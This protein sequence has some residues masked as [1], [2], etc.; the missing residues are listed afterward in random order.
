MGKL[1]QYIEQ[2]LLDMY[3][4]YTYNIIPLTYNLYP[5]LLDVMPF[6]HCE[7]DDGPTD[8]SDIRLN[9]SLP[10]DNGVKIVHLWHLFNPFQTMSYKGAQVLQV[11]AKLVHKQMWRWHH[12]KI[13]VGSFCR[14][15]V[16]SQDGDDSISAVRRGTRCSGLCISKD[17]S[18][19][20]L[21]DFRTCASFV[22]AWLR[23]SPRGIPNMEAALR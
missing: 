1:S 10:L 23:W 18:V 12:G 13:D 3:F 16:R 15:R 11:S 19:R 6:L 5:E 20:D 21:C 4:N 2:D 7:K 9:L 14:Q 8:A 22:N 17:L